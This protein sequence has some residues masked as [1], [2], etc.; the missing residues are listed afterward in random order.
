MGAFDRRSRARLGCAVHPVHRVL[1]GRLFTLDCRRS[2]HCVHCAAISPKSV[3]VGRGVLLVCGGHCPGG[4]GR[5]R[6]SPRLPGVWGRRSLQVGRMGNRTENF[7]RHRFSRS[8]CVSAGKV[9]LVQEARCDITGPSTRTH[10]CFR[11][12]FAL[13]SGAP[14][15]SDVRRHGELLCP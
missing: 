8:G 12:R 7:G 5:I 2:S 13:A 6:P 14:V 3:A 9:H 11:A 10:K 4:S 15:K 1:V